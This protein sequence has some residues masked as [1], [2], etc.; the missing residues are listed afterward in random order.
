MKCLLAKKGF[1]IFLTPTNW[2]LPFGLHFRPKAI[3]IYFL[4]IALIVDRKEKQQSKKLKKSWNDI[5]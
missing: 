2:A 3:E 1:G 4:C 5:A